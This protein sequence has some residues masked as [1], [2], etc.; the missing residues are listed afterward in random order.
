MIQ[1]AHIGT[2]F[3]VQTINGSVSRRTSA[4]S[5]ILQA[6]MRHQFEIYAHSPRRAVPAPRAAS[7]VAPLGYLQQSPLHFVGDNHKAV[8]VN[9][10]RGHDVRYPFWPGVY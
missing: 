9:S 7:L 6:H 5:I 1:K 4:P 8:G 10:L 3:V 2:Y